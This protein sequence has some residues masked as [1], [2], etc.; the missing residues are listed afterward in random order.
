MGR[1]ASVSVRRLTGS[2]VNTQACLLVSWC[3][4]SHATKHTRMQAHMVVADPVWNLAR[5]DIG[6]RTSRHACKQACWFVDGTVW[7]STYKQACLYVDAH[8]VCHAATF[9]ASK[10]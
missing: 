3:T 6:E 7:A 4:C 2:Q 9:I 10:A 1:P 5:N 8:A